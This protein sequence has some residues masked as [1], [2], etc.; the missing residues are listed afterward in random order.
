MPL[1]PHNL[2]SA[3]SNLR[4]AL[5]D[6]DI[7][8]TTSA[9]A[10]PEGKVS[11]RSLART[12][13]PVN[14]AIVRMSLAFT[15][16]NVSTAFSQGRVPL[17]AVA[18][19]SNCFLP[20]RSKFALVSRWNAPIRK[21]IKTRP[22]PSSPRHTHPHHPLSRPTPRPHSSSF[23]VAVTIAPSTLSFRIRPPRGPFSG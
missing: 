5:G 19:F 9:I 16:A 11:A 14:G 10:R 13:N 22:S 12:Y 8:R 6:V 7:E 23:P 21:H 18:A 4:A 1:D 17:K 20:A 3:P 15:P 2:W